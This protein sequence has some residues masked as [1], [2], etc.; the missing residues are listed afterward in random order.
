MR[1]TT[2]KPDM[3]KLIERAWYAHASGVQINIMDIPMLFAEA[4]KLI[5]DGLPVDDAIKSLIPKYRLN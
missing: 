4:R 5:S 1:K 2:R 3:D